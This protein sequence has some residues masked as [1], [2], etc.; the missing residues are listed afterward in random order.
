MANTP[1]VQEHPVLHPG[2]FRDTIPIGMH[3]DAGGFTEHESLIVLSWN[4]LLGTG[5][6]RSKRF[7][8]TVLLKKECT[9]ATLE[10]VF[11]IFAWCV[12]S[13]LTGL[14][15]KHDWEQMPLPGGGDSMAGGWRACLTHC[16]GDW[17]WYTDRAES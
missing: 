14:M 5:S 16:R 17:Q 3:G 8:F 10:K 11:Q 4:S 13:M 12:N 2:V 9:R 1:F 6:T 15:P 7:L